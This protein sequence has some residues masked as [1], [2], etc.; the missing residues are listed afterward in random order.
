[1]AC[2][3]APRN[4]LDFEEFDNVLLFGLLAVETAVF[5]I[6]TVG[7]FVH[8]VTSLEQS[9]AVGVYSLPWCC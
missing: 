9:E 3:F 1:M 4:Y 7:L 6:E 8:S 2:L 5:G